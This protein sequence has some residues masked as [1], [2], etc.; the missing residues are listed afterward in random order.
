MK[1][2]YDMFYNASLTIQE[3]AKLLRKKETDAERILWERLKSK[4]LMG[5]KFRRQHPVSQ[6][7][8]DFYCHE[9][10]LVIEVDGKIHNRPEN[11]EYDRNRTAELEQFGL[12]V[13]RFSND[14]IERNIEKV[15]KCINDAIKSSF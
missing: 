13:L 6:F 15:L 9:H 2:K 1:S 12:K 10:K 4:Q 7:I 14:E 11:K 8:V 3:R 5:M